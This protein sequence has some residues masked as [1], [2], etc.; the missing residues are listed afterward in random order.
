MG[1]GH[2]VLGLG[3]LGR[4]LLRPGGARRQLVV[5]VEQVVE[6]PVV[7]L[8]RLVR[9]G[10]LEP[11]GERVDADA[12]LV[13]V[14][15][16]E[17]LVLDGTALWFRSEV[18]GVDGAVALADRVPADDQGGRLLVVHRH[19]PEGLADVPA[20]GDRVG[21]AVGA[22]GVDVD[23]AHLHG[24]EWPAELAVAAIALVA[25]PGVLGTP[26]DLLR[27]EDVLTSEAEA[28]RLE[29]HRL[30]SDVA[31]KDD[32]VG[33]GDLPPVLLLDR[34][35]QPAGLVEADVVRPAVERGEA[36]GALAAAAAAVGDAVGTSGVP[37]HPDEQRP[38]VAVVGGPPVLRRGHHVDEVLL[39]GLDVEGLELL[40]VVEV[41]THQPGNGH[42][43]AQDAQVDLV[44]PPVL[45]RIRSSRL[46]GRGLD[47]WVF[48]LRHVRPSP[49]WMVAADGW[50]RSMPPY[51]RGI[52]P[53]R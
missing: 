36:L 31:G 15:P 50:W 10:P 29:P 22:F 47:Y 42:V 17:A 49:S 18:L 34:P 40:G 52:G 30:I 32:Q 37:R 45:V 43:L 7:P 6:V 51:S 8:R 16:A 23:Q 19:P 9:P 1:I 39:E 46:D 27:L 53:S 5:V 3:V 14:L 13:A 21:V 33:P 41:L 4:P 26:E 38:V 12:A 24:A 48:A 35:E 20:G 28:E 25:E 11:A 2:G 44:R